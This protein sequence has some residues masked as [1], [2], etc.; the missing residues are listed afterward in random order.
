MSD[1]PEPNQPE[2]TQPAQPPPPPD[3]EQKGIAVE[4]IG[5]GAALGSFALQA[6]Q[7]FKPSARSSDPPPSDPPAPP[8]PK[9]E[10]PPGVDGD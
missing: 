7:T 1:Q 6:Y 4:L 10:L 9:I 3:L 5:T 2:P 8:P